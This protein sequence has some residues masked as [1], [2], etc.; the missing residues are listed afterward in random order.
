MGVIKMVQEWLKKNSE[1]FYF[2][3]RVLFGLLFLLHGLQKV[4]GILA[5]K[6]QLFSLMGLAGVIELVGGALVL[7]GLF[8]TYVALVSAVEMLVAYFMAHA[9][10][11]WNPLVNKG[12]AAVLFFGAFLVLAAYGSGKWAL[13]SFW[14]K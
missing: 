12:E 13:D 1:K 14:K 7:V 10:N 4:S 5:G 9:S 11:G 3:F 6:M 8:T 2:V